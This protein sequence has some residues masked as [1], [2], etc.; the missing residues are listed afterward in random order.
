MRAIVLI[1]WC[2]QIFKDFKIRYSLVPSQH[3]AITRTAR[4]NGETKFHDWNVTVFWISKK[5]LKK[6]AVNFSIDMSGKNCNS[7]DI[8]VL[9]DGKGQRNE[10]CFKTAYSNCECECVNHLSPKLNPICYLLA[11]IA[12]DF[13][14]V[15]RIRVKSLTLRLLM[16][17]VYIYMEHLLLMFLDHTQ[18]RTTIGRTPLDEWSARR[19]DL[20]L[21]TH[22]NHNRQTS[23]PP[24]EFEPTISLGERP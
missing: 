23:M 1:L 16:S 10:L 24:V 8:C 20:Y 14:H 4:E 9:G 19:R 13:L 3:A 5:L 2:T 12:H 6:T 17:Y 11:L 18:R 22:D 15:S 7:N 21:T